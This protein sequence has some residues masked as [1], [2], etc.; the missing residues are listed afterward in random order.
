MKQPLTSDTEKK[1]IILKLEFS[2]G[3]VWSD[4]DVKEALNKGISISNN[5]AAFGHHLNNFQGASAFF[6]YD[7][8]MLVKKFSN[9]QG[10]TMTHLLDCKAVEMTY[11]EFIA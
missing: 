4:D 9:L 2:Q 1:I 6:L 7:H 8:S 5:T 10:N 3:K 11:P